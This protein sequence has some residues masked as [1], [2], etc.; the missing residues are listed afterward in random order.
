MGVIIPGTTPLCRVPTYFEPPTVTATAGAKPD[1]IRSWNFRFII[2][3]LEK[4]AWPLNVLYQLLNPM[5]WPKM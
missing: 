1:R 2:K 4:K 5:Q 3:H